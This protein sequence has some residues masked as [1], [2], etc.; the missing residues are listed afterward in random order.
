MNFGRILFFILLFNFV[1]CS[2]AP[3]VSEKTARTLGHGNWET[4]I[5]LSPAP[6]I[7][8]GR[9]FGDSFDLH[10]SY[11]SQL[12]PLVEV[13]G[14]FALAQNK[15]GLSLAV[16]GGG[17]TDGNNSTGYYAGPIFSMKNGWFEFYALGKYNSVTWTAD[18]ST[19]VEDSVFNFSLT[20]DQTF[21][22]W[23]ATIGINLWFND[24]FGLNINGK[25]FF[26]DNASDEG[27]KLIPSAHFLF[28][29]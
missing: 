27:D 24:G 25:K 2:L 9:G 6:S 19:E 5:G 8:I 11:E 14:K 29:F 3:V 1:S 13:G 12:V 17:F 10:F 21:D 4:N 20:E 15:E 28:R 26:L 18:A 7:T 23:L 22:Y 16:F